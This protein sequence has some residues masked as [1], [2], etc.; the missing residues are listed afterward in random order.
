MIV[1]RLRSM[2]KRLLGIVAVFGLGI[3]I[4][5]AAAPLIVPKASAQ[6]ALLPSWEYICLE[7][8][9]RDP[10]ASTAQANKLGAQ[11][12][13]VALLEPLNGEWCFKRQKP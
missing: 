13:E 9:T 2:N 7:R 4:G 5:C 8:P 6:Q 12:W 10:E 11:R 3:G 1:I